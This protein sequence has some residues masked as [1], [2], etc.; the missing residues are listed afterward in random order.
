MSVQQLVRAVEDNDHHQLD[1][2][3]Q[4][5]M[6]F[7]RPESAPVAEPGPGETPETACVPAAAARR[8][9]D[10]EPAWAQLLGEGVATPSAQLMRRPGSRSS[11][12]RLPS[13]TST[14][15]RNES[16]VGC[17]AA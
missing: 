12:G 13:Y 5:A 3:R 8:T 4:H 10:E 11:D 14:S 6:P 7:T 9:A 2:L 15:L 1:L 16:S 17:P